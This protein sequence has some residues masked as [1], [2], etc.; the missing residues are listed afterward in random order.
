[1]PTTEDL[2]AGLQA[3]DIGHRWVVLGF[4]DLTSPEMHDL[5]QRS[6]PG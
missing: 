5:W 2:D 6:T 4:D 3:L 1:M